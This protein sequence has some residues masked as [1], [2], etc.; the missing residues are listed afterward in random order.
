M[1]NFK[2]CTDPFWSVQKLIKKIKLKNI[3][4][5]VVVCLITDIF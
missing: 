4:Q 2:M 5:P 1:S 3:G